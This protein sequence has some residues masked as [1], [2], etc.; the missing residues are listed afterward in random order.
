MKPDPPNYLC[1][2]EKKHSNLNI[3]MIMFVPNFS[4]QGC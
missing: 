2:I 4:S 1:A 3:F